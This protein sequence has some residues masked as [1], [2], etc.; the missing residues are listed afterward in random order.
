MANQRKI[1]EAWV[2]DKKPSTK[3]VSSGCAVDRGATAACNV[4]GGVVAWG[5]KACP[6]CGKKPSAPI[7]LTKLGPKHLAVI[8][9]VVLALGFQLTSKPSQPSAPK[10]ETL[11]LNGDTRL[12]LMGKLY[13]HGKECAEVLSATRPTYDSVKV[14]CKNLDGVNSY[15]LLPDG[16]V[17]TL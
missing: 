15:L 12:A 4:C 3:D 1:P 14:V 2:V 9:V 17:L 5:I 8:A 13:N 11:D 16:R 7:P 10:V 6:H